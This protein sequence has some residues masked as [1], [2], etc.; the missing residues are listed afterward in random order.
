MDWRDLF[1]IKKPEKARR[2]VVHLIKA[3]QKDIDYD[4][5]IQ[6]LQTIAYFDGHIWTRL[7][8]ASVSS[9]NFKFFR[10]L[11]ET[12]NPFPENFYRVL[13]HGHCWA[14]SA[15]NDFMIQPFLETQQE[16]PKI[17]HRTVLNK[18]RKLAPRCFWI[19]QARLDQRELMMVEND[20]K[21][22]EYAIFAIQQNQVLDH[23][24]PPVLTKMIC[25]YLSLLHPKYCRHVLEK[26][27]G[28]TRKWWM[29]YQT[30]VNFLHLK[31]FVPDPSAL[32]PP[33]HHLPIQTFTTYNEALDFAQDQKRGLVMVLDLDMS[34]MQYSDLENKT[35]GCFIV[36][37][38]HNFEFLR[39]VLGVLEEVNR[40]FYWG[41]ENILSKYR[42]EIYYQGRFFPDA[43]RILCDTTPS[44]PETQDMAKL[45]LSC[46][47]A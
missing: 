45:G 16:A 19:L 21:T 13:I 10:A 11:P 44:M 25:E 4:Q 41:G 27:L 26:S 22:P 35:T 20:P 14:D 9:R 8:H 42:V 24:L 29:G 34:V 46:F 40:C 33:Q 31:R 28:G 15:M 18:F 17:I 3:Q 37:V 12:V 1:E 2:F 5:I 47:E 32:S 23:Y 39:G 36:L 7:L 30:F 6:H 38:G 43:N